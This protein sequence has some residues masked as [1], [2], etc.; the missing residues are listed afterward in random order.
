MSQAGLDRGLSWG[1][2]VRTPVTNSVTSGCRLQEVGLGAY[3]QAAC[4]GLGEHL[5]VRYSPDAVK[6]ALLASPA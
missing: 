6:A 1:D 4:I 2:R 5:E 3:I